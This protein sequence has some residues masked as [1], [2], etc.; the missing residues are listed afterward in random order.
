MVQFDESIAAFGFLGN[1]TR[2]TKYIY[3]TTITNVSS[4]FLS[5][6]PELIMFVA[7]QS[8]FNSEVC[9]VN[10][11][12][13]NV[14]FFKFVII[15]AFLSNTSN[16]VFIFT[17]FTNSWNQGGRSFPSRTAFVRWSNI[18]GAIVLDYQ[19]ENLFQY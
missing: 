8:S 15:L 14:F 16:V 11:I 6:E 7:K 19:I 5:S 13:C 18:E 4:C 3:F 2:H 9:Y 17:A 1:T 10:Y 12:K